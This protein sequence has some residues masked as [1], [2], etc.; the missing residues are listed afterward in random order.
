MSTGRLRLFIGLAGAAAALALA[1]CADMGPPGGGGDPPVPAAPAIYGASTMDTALA[2]GTPAVRIFFLFPGGPA[3]TAGLRE[4]DVITTAAGKPVGSYGDLARI[5]AAKRPGDVLSVGLVRGDQRLAIDVKLQARQPDYN[6]RFMQAEVARMQT[7]EQAAAQAE[8]AGDYQGAFDH[9]VAAARLIGAAR[10]VLP[11]STEQFDGELARIST[12]LPR[13][14][15]PPVV[16][17]GVEVEGNRAIALLRTA[18]SDFD[19]DAAADLFEQAIYEAPWVADLY[20]DEGLVELKAGNVRAGAVQLN[21]YLILYPDAPDAAAIRAKIAGAEP[22]AAEQRPWQPFLGTG[23]MSG[24]QSERLSLR[25]R[26]LVLAVVKPPPPPD[27]ES[28]LKPGDPLC[29]GTIDG[30]QFHGQCVFLDADPRFTN[31][32]GDK[33]TFPAEG[34]IEGSTFRIRTVTHLNFHYTSCVID[35]TQEGVFRTRIGALQ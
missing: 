21:R 10:A 13:L 6:A 22:L 7:E 20:R 25:G 11:N 15:P 4:G 26:T 31:C 33:K 3:E 9:R 8:D 24:D 14:S 23:L 35:S 16:P 34:A 30:T 27:P 32:F 18:R 17:P 19:N 5:V 29:S 12:L 28:N 2:S 1:G